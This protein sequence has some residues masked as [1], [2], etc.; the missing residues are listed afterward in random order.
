MTRSSTAASPK[1]N[2]ATTR[3][4]FLLLTAV[5]A[6]ACAPE[7]GSVEPM[8]GIPASTRWSTTRS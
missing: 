4:T 7:S 8:E 5:C 3:R 2:T 6:A 1:M